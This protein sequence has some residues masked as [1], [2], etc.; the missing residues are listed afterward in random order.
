MKLPDLIVRV[1]SGRMVAVYIT[2]NAE[3]KR[4]AAETIW[5]S[6]YTPTAEDQQD[7][8]SALQEY[9]AKHGCR[10]KAL[11]PIVAA[12]PQQAQRIADHFCRTGQRSD[13]AN[14]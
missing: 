11:A 8:Y 3:E 5:E 4:L 9:F 12:T 6:D 13:P 1:T 14:K 2:Q 10:I 7:L